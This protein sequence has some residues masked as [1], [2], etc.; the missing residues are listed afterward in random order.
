MTLQVRFLDRRSPPHLFTLVLASGIAALSMNVFLP[1]LPQMAQHFDVSYSLMQLSVSLYI[2]MT[3]IL[4]VVIG[5][6][7]DSFGRRPVMLAAAAVF[8]LATAGTMLAPNFGIFLACR[9]LQAVIATG[10]AVSRAVVR[11]MV[12]PDQAAGMIGWV[13][14]GMSVV[15]MLSPVL[16]GFLGTAF[17]WQASFVLMMVSGIV[18][19]GVVWADLGETRRGAGT[20]LRDQA[21]HYPALLRSQRFWGYALAAGLGAG[22]FFAFL[23]G[24]PYVGAQVYG[25]DPAMLGLYF[26]A[27]ASG[28]LIGNGFSGRYAA[29]LGIAWMVMAGALIS[30]TG[31]LVMLALTLAGLGSAEIFFGMTIFVG[32]GNGL[33]MPS[34][35]AGMLSVRPDLAGSAAGLGGACVTG[36]GA[37]FAAFAGVALGWGDSELPLILLMLVSAA[38]A[39]PC[40]LWVRHRARRIGTPS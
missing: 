7:S 30:L 15:P 35:N 9:L 5:P 17:G 38:G 19:F 3:A 11:D 6:V 39:I 13:T 31:L 22:A 33:L 26:G 34:A 25:L 12:G 2:A 27:P 24:A 18:L 1:S 37:A 29:R 28:Y 20:T 16:G 10:F 4:Q 40:L 23:G 21:R 32:V 36:F 14:M 8:V